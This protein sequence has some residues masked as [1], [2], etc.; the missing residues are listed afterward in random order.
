VA[1]AALSAACAHGRAAP[2]PPDCPPIADTSRVALDT[3]AAAALAGHYDVVSVNTVRGY[4]GYVSRHRLH[5]VALDPARRLRTR[6]S[7]PGR[8][9]RIDTLLLA[10]RYEWDADGRVYG[11]TAEVFPRGSLIVGCVLCLDASPTLHTIDALTADGFRGRW[12]NPQT[13]IGVAVDERGRRLPN[14]GGYYCA[15]RR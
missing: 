1:V 4:D 9:T 2:A 12:S 11:D 7:F 14:P 6:P 10:G 5:L 15:R 13:G 8:A 3:T